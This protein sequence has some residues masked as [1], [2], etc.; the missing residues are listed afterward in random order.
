MQPFTAV[1]R[2]KKEVN[3]FL[4]QVLPDGQSVLFTIATSEKS[5]NDATIVVQSLATG[6]RHVLVEGGTCGRYVPSGHLLFG[7]SNSLYAV[8]FDL[9]RLAVTGTPVEML[10]G[11][12]LEQTRGPSHFACSNNGTL[13]YLPG[14]ESIDLNELILVNRSGKPQW[15]SQKRAPFAQP[16]S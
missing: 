6:E 14:G 1:D 15:M 10:S 13:I 12:V 11:V 5:F 7:R 3:H 16:R 2:T 9:N 4:P 8:P